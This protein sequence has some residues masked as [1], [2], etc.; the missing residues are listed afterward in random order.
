MAMPAASEE[1]NSPEQQRRQGEPA[2]EAEEQ[3]QP[4]EGRGDDGVHL[5]AAGPVHGP[6]PEGEGPHHRGQAVGEGPP[7]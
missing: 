5:A 2:D 6:D 1:T 4:A 3:G 7:P